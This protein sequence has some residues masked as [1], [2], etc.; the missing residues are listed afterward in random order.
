VE[1]YIAMRILTLLTGM[2]IGGG[3]MI[4]FYDGG[5][6]LSVANRQLGPVAK[7]AS[8][9]A[10]PVAGR[11]ESKGPPAKARVVIR[12]I[13]EGSAAPPAEAAPAKPPEPAPSASPG[14]L[15]V[16]KW[17]YADHVTRLP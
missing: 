8:A 17:P 3:A 14:A 6:E 1:A 9:G 2:I 4:W 12:D 11:G 10:G 16:I 15:I 5:G 7:T 13:T